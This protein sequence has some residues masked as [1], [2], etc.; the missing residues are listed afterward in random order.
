MGLFT[1]KSRGWLGGLLEVRV[2]L[3]HVFGD[4]DVAFKEA[5]F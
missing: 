1:F 4:V 3:T 2:G 5:L